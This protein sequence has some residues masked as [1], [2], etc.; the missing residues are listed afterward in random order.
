MEVIK[1]R[2]GFSKIHVYELFKVLCF[3]TTGIIFFL[4]NNFTIHITFFFGKGSE[5]ST[6]YLFDLFC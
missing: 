5:L 4:R 2:E 6:S 1:A 3:L